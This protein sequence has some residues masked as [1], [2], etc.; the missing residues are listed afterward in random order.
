V[1]RHVDDIAEALLYEGYLLWPYRASSLKNRHRWT[2]GGVYPERWSTHGGQGDAWQM[3]SEVLVEGDGG[4]ALSVE[5][6][7]LHVVD[8]RGGRI[9]GEEATERR[10]PVQARTL[11]E[12]VRDPAHV[13]IDVAAGEE[14]QPLH[15]PTGAASEAVVRRWLSLAGAIDVAA[16]P[17]G[18]GLWRVHARL[19]N[20]TPFDGAIRQDAQ[21]HTFA[22]SHFVLRVD[23]GAFV[24]AIDPPAHLVAAARTCANVGAWPVLV[25]EDGERHTMLA[26]PIILYDYP[27]IAAESPQSLFDATEIDQLLI[28]NVLS[29]GEAEKREIRESDPR[30]RALVD[31]CAS[32]GPADLA[33]LHGTF[34]DVHAIEDGP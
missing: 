29:L 7:F 14:T 4:E 20:L 17:L 34:R 15:A 27:R 31:R 26:S 30:G 2:F 13:A 24:S 18:T 32:L 22:A 11:H 5:L 6:R 33:R 21:R 12:L 8:R 3:Q 10:V 9:D 28:L 19:S 1:T 23:G 16:T 25:G